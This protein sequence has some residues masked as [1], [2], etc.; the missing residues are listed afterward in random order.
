MSTRFTLV[1][2]SE[3]LLLGREPDWSRPV[4]VDY[5]VD[6]AVDVGLSGREARREFHAELRLA[7]RCEL[8]LMGADE[9]AVV[10]EV[11]AER[12]M[13]RVVVPLWMDKLTPGRFVAERV[14]QSDWALGWDG[15]GQ[16][17][18][19]SLAGVNVAALPYRYLLPFV[20]GYLEETTTLSMVTPVVAR[21]RVVLR[22]DSP[23]AYAV[24]SVVSGDGVW[25]ADLMPNWSRVDEQ[26]VY[27]VERYAL[28][29]GRELAVG[30]Q[31]MGVY[32]GLDAGFGPMLRDEVAGLIAHFR[33]CGG[34]AAVWSVP[35]W[36][37]PGVVV[38]GRYA[39]KPLSLR[40][41][42][43]GV[44]ESRVRV[45]ETPWAGVVVERRPKTAFCYRFTYE[46]PEAAVWCFT[47]YERVVRFGGQD[48]EPRWIEHGE[49]RDGFLGD[50]NHLELRSAVWDGNPLG[51]FMPHSVD[52]PLRVE[53][54]RVTV[55]TGDGALIWSGAVQSASLRDRK[56][57]AR[58]TAFGGIL[59]RAF[60][61]VL[62]QRQDNA[63]L[64][65]TAN[66]LSAESWVQV[67][68]VTGV[69]GVHLSVSGVSGSAGYFTGGWI[70]VG[71]GASFEMRV[72]VN[73]AG[74]TLRL[75]KPLRFGGIGSQV[76]CFPGYAG[77]WSDAVAKFANGDRFLGFP[78][79]PDSNPTLTTV[80]TD[81]GG[82]KK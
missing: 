77:D 62:M 38:Q 40:W 45:V 78:F 81:R 74:N 53:V 75:A 79:I 60:P 63:A 51:K 5:A 69:R 11:L 42:S 68:S 32:R 52:V 21:L 41:L 55:D 82:G 64:F 23:V 9:V 24:G 50:D 6:A 18:L 48:F 49:M 25:P 4:E 8:L 44:A 61:G 20:V 65:S 16:W 47:D 43:G 80:E 58:A 1:D 70:E 2:G 39:Q 37:S 22:E 7:L 13:H 72:V 67:G 10:R 3:A 19:V 36:A 56:I 28:G 12:A 57:T 30:H 17:S 59:E 73:H 35:W 15:D 54:F 26:S 71:S 34:S 29:H 31:E 76:R 33:A 66:G 27:D 14:H 46:A